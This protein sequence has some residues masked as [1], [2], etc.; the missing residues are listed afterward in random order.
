[1]LLQLYGPP[2]H[3]ASQGWRQQPADV[4]LLLG[5]HAQS[6]PSKCNASMDLCTWPSSSQE[7]KLMI[8]PIVEYLCHVAVELDQ[9]FFLC[10]LRCSCG[11]CSLFYL[12]C[13][14]QRWIFMCQTEFP[15][16]DKPHLILAYNPFQK[17]LCLIC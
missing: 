15:F 17:L 1:M 3:R 16:L 14:L 13:M 8:C 10:L 6:L 7:E 2:Q 5:E 11:F 4:C 9:M 12:Y